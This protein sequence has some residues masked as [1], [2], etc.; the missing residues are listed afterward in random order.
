MSES[1]LAQLNQLQDQP[2][3]AR[4]RILRRP[5][6]EQLTGL[7]RSA[8]YAAMAAGGFPKPLKLT[9]RAV[10]WTDSS[11]DAWISSRSAASSRVRCRHDSSALRNPE[12]PV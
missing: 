2:A 8:I 11:I 4:R 5:E 10:G 12:L 9:A 1:T 6:V 7:S 3:Q